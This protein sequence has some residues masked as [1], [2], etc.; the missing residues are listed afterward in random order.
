MEMWRCIPSLC[1][2][3][4]DRSPFFLLL[5]LVLFPTK[6]VLMIVGEQNE[7]KKKKTF[8]Q[9]HRVASD[10]PWDVFYIVRVHFLR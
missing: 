4:G 8:G 5:N 1:F 7:K 6:M 3:R 9:K 2:K 10:P